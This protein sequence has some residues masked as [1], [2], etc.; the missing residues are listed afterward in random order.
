M[1]GDVA[2]EPRGLIL[3]PSKHLMCFAGII[4]RVSSSTFGRTVT[5]RNPTLY[6]YLWPRRV[7]KYSTVF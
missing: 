7:A 5:P 4:G 3:R 2:F 6:L 1:Y